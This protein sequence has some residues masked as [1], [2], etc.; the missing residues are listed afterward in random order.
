MEKLTKEVQN[1][2]LKLNPILKETDINF[3]DPDNLI[4]KIPNKGFAKKKVNRPISMYN[5]GL[6]RMMIDSILKKYPEG[7]AVVNENIQEKIRKR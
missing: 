7:S 5:N 1:S 4:I 6:L 3:A 2:T